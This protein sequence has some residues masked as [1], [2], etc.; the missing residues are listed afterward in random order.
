MELFCP[1]D[2]VTVDSTH[3]IPLNPYMSS[4]EKDL[5]TS[6][7]ETSNY[8]Y[9]YD[10][11]QA[12]EKVGQV[13]HPFS[14]RIKAA[15]SLHRQSIGSAE[16][17]KRRRVEFRS[18]I[19]IIPPSQKYCVLDSSDSEE[20]IQDSN[21]S[22]SCVTSIKGEGLPLKNKSILELE[23]SDND[24]EMASLENNGDQIKKQVEDLVL[25]VFESAGEIAAISQDQIITLE[26]D[27]SEIKIT[28]E[29]FLETIFGS[30]I[31]AIDEIQSKV[32]CISED[33]SSL[34][35]AVTESTS[36]ESNQTDIEVQ[37]PKMEEIQQRNEGKA[38]IGLFTT[39]FLQGVEK[40]KESNIYQLIKEREEDR[41]IY[42]KTESIVEAVVDQLENQAVKANSLLT[43]M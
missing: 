41:A 21:S 14:G 2:I 12:L 28:S 19:E 33:I 20:D 27:L 22:L 37:S 30:A 39:E 18:E 16:F 4:S 11:M 31:S 34:V 6:E 7:H 17:P 43:G 25:G 32:K 29:D 1:K 9:D 5:V 40:D 15:L 10:E 26:E 42:D 13:T 38:F 35:A 24:E 3:Q 36:L 23:L 8:F